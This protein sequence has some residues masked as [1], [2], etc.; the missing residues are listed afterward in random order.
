M[1]RV[2]NSACRVGRESRMKALPK[3][4]AR[5]SCCIAFNCGHSRSLTFLWFSIVQ[6]LCCCCADFILVL[7]WFRVGVVW[8]CVGVEGGL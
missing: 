8:V 6:W 1:T 5:G 2:P 4:S 7:C 3:I